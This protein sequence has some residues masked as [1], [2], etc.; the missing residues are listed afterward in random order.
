MLR[1]GGRL[2][3]STCTFAPE[4][5]E[6]QIEQFLKANPDYS[7][8]SQEK[9]LPHKVMGEGHFAAVLQKGAIGLGG[10]SS[11]DSGG[12]ANLPLF[13]TGKIDKKNLAVWQD[14]AKETLKVSFDRLFM[15]GEHL[16]SAPEAMPVC[17]VQTLRAGVYLGDFK[18][19]RFEPAHALAMALKADEVQTVDVP[20]ETAMEYLKGNTFACPE[21]LKGWK[22]VTCHG[23]PLGWCKCSGGTAKN[24]YPKGLRMYV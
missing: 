15:A 23:Y 14:F 6:G 7:L 24:H 19:G 21:E 2:V 22:V 12:E 16:C 11:G 3:Y 1:R 9:L 5:D 20:E 18:A 13:K 8:I 10:D 17:G 4:E